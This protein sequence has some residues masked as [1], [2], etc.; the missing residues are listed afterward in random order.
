MAKPASKVTRAVVTGP[1]APYAPAL[2]AALRERGY[3]PLSAVNTMRL[4]AHLSRWLEASG[5]SAGELNSE[6]A[7]RYAAARCA[8]GR[9]SARLGRSI[10]AILAMLAEAGAL[11]PQPPAA[12]EPASEN[13]RMLTAFER[14][15][16][17]E[18]ALAA[19]TAAAYVARARRFLAGLGSDGV[20]G[21]TA[22]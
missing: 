17:H 20:S 5:L 8:E 2:A 10:A 3:T 19:T 21:L 14:H 6:L 18:R 13:D 15:L 9:T 12:P 16:L 1:L 4:V 22:A 7:E 11:A